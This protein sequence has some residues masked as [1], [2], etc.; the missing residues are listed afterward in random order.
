MAT[1]APS[2]GADSVT[3]LTRTQARVRVRLRVRLRLRL[4]LRLSVSTATTAHSTATGCTQH[5][6][7]MRS[8]CA[9]HTRC[10]PTAGEGDAQPLRS[11]P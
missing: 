4:R 6:Q 5:P 8:A 1:A 2:L 9:A 3:Y 10:M 11:G 7:R